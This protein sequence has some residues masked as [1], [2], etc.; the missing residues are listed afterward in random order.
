M[1]VYTDD[2]TVDNDTLLLRR[3]PSNPNLT[4]VKDDNLGIYRP[5]SASFEDHVNK[6]PMSIVLSD[7]LEALGRSLESALHGHEIGFSL[8]AFTAGLARQCNQSVVRDPVDDEPAHGLVVG[9]KSKKVR[10]ALAKGC[11]WIVEPDL[12]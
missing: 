10:R 4:I 9:N 2:E 1:P 5:S 12:E 3:I 7:T 11:Q 6:T 8:A